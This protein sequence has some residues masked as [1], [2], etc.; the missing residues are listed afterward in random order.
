VSGLELVQ[1]RTE[2]VHLESKILNQ[3]SKLIAACTPCRNIKIKDK[4]NNYALIPEVIKIIV[5]KI[6][7]AAK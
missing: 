7:D 3:T 4:K 2:I 5:R 6:N 1:I